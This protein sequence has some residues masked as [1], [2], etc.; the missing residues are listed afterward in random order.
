MMLRPE[1]GALKCSL[2]R[3]S[4]FL[5]LALALAMP[6]Q[7][8]SQT[9]SDVSAERKHALELYRQN[10]FVEAIPLLEKLVIVL[11]SDITLLESLGWA[12]FVVTGSTKD[13]EARKQMRARA[14]GF[15]ERAKD[16]G[17]DSELLR[18]GLEGLSKP[19]TPDAP[20][21]PV[22]SADAALR[23]GEAAHA[24][25]D[26]D[27]AIKGYKRALELDPNL[28]IAAL[29]IGD[30]YF[31]KG[32]QATDPAEKKQ[33]MGVAGDWFTRAIAI[34]ENL[35]TAYRYWGDALMAIGD[36]EGARAKFID[37]I[38]AEPWN[39]KPYMGLTQWAN[40]Y[41][42]NM[43][44]PQIQQPTPSVSTSAG[45]GN[46]TTVIDPRTLTEHSPDYYWSFYDRTR[47][48]Y[49]TASFQKDHPGEQEYRHSLRE[50]SSALRAVAE[51]VS[52]D[53]QSGKIKTSDP[54]LERLVKLFK[55][56]LIEAY[57][58]FTRLDEGIVR[59]YA[60]YKK[61]SRDKLRLYWNDFVI[62]KEATF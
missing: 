8:F 52:K 62:A 33:L 35:E 7:A 38:I 5:L 2:G 32:Y 19:D 44:H 25:G 59:D 61:S 43:S 39:R 56:D 51:L 11:P 4:Q 58:F 23:D 13:S 45:E 46:T 26:L 49:K 42:V 24:R 18:A 9:T 1:P 57:I 40:K 34:D 14:L 41:K 47:A 15:L 30:M 53:L 36:K 21:S 48:V 20:V 16:L 31:K 54:S 60:A 12:M 3:W 29:F 10:K 22:G 37:A 6:I 55:A 50:E 28:Y 27:D 17:D